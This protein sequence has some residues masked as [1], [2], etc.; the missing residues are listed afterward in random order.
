MDGAAGMGL[1][2]PP[3]DLFPYLQQHPLFTGLTED[4]IRILQTIC[5]PRHIEVGS[6]IFVQRMHG[7]SA[8]LLVAGEVMLSVEREHGER[9]LGVLEAPDA[10]GELSLIQP[11]PRKVTATARTQVGVIEIARRDF[12]NLQKQRPQ[13]CAKLLININERFGQRLQAVG[14]LLDKLVDH[15]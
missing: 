11:S 14:P 7:E 4:G 15:L 13:A 10:F 8:F 2:L 5:V 9:E 6:P 1:N 12:I 3:M